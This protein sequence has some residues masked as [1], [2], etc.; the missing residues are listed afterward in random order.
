[1]TKSA[2]IIA[3][4]QRMYH[5]NHL[6]LGFLLRFTGLG[7]VASAGIPRRSASCLMAA[8][9]PGNAFIVFMVAV[10]VTVR[11]SCR[12]TCTVETP[13][14]SIDRDGGALALGE[15]AGLDHVSI[16]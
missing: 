14:I 15:A 7:P 9:I 10:A 13:S 6:G 8:N 4:N 5:L 12:V 1:M 3:A 16:S 2:I 11:P